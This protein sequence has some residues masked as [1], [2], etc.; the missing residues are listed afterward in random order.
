MSG[1]LKKILGK[2]GAR[3]T[4]REGH[5]KTYDVSAIEQLS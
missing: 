2:Q 1:K 4:A 5:N 3:E